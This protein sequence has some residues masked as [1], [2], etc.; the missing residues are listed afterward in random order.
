MLQ[1][2]NKHR[3]DPTQKIRLSNK[4]KGKGKYQKRS[5][6]GKNNMTKAETADSDEEKKLYAYY[7]GNSRKHWFHNSSDCYFIKNL[8]NKGSNK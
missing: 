2:K 4:S 7:K 1:T 6:K 8:G 5:L 3:K